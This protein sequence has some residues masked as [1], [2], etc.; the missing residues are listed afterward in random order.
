MEG[1]PIQVQFVLLLRWAK[2][3]CALCWATAT[4]GTI[5]F[6]FMTSVYRERSQWTTL[7][8][9]DISSSAQPLPMQQMS[10]KTCWLIVYLWCWIFCCLHLNS[11]VCHGPRIGDLTQIHL[12]P[13]CPNW[14]GRSRLLWV[15][16]LCLLPFAQHK[17]LPDNR[18]RDFFFQSRVRFTQN[19]FSQSLCMRGAQ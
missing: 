10:N 6:W 3:R 1:R 9:F 7:I 15:L 4:W 19:H 8:V 2:R 17:T 18:G 16:G 5:I 12:L 13:F 14:N 11:N